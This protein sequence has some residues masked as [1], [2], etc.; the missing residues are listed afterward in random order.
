LTVAE[1]ARLPAPDHDGLRLSLK[2]WRR[3]IE[4]RAGFARGRGGDARGGVSGAEGAVWPSGRG[5][6]A[7]LGLRNPKRRRDGPRRGRRSGM[8][9]VLTSGP[10]LLLQHRTLC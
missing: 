6:P 9:A 7:P 5:A 4:R 1:P 10:Q 8:G 2:S 3:Q